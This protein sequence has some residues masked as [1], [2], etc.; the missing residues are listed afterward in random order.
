MKDW[1]L[2][3]EPRERVFV[4]G[5]AVAVLL[6][7]LWALVINPLQ[8]SRAAT[9]ERVE[10]KLETLAFL[11]AAAAELAGAGNMPAAGPE[12]AGQP[13]V[14]VVDRTAR[15]AGLGTALTR[16]QPVGE[17]GIRV[18][19]DEASFDA[20]ARWLATLGATA[21]LSIEAASFDRTPAEGRVNASLVLRQGLQ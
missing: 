19:L 15:A 3:L 4:G 7:L 8:A 12:L 11:R 6:L 14:V 9:A 18:R 10:T 17:D 1:F 16:N 21:G 5:G 2:G 20:V 13:L